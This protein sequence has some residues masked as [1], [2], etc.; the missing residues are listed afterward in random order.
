M[1]NPTPLSKLGTRRKG[2]LENL[3]GNMGEGVI[4]E[5]IDSPVFYLLLNR[6]FEK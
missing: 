3:T 1:K 6:G 2:V 4:N 5:L